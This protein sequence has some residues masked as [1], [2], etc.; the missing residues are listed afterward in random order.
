MINDHLSYTLV[1]PLLV[2]T[3]SWYND[4]ECGFSSISAVKKLNL[5][6]WKSPKRNCLICKNTVVCSKIQL[7]ENKNKNKNKWPDRKNVR[8]TG[9]LVLSGFPVSNPVHVQDGSGS[10]RTGYRSNL[11]STGWTGRSNPI[12]TTLL[13]PYAYLYVLSQW[14][15]IVT[16]RYSNY[17]QFNLVLWWLI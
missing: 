7:F 10:N 3:S 11:S 5:L 2:S 14:W 13:I 9:F 6:L 1:C 8:T 4:Y 17:L 15:C 16:Y 12:F